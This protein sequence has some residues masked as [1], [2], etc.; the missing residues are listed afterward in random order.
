MSKALNFAVGSLFVISAALAV[1]AYSTNQQLV[2]EAASEAGY[3]FSQ[4]DDFKRN[5]VRNLLDDPDGQTIVGVAHELSLLRVDNTFAVCSDQDEIESSQY[6]ELA[7]I[8]DPLS[9]SAPK[10]SNEI[11]MI[12]SLDQGITDCQFRVIEAIA[13][14]STSS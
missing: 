3:T 6:L 10:V 12:L 4:V 13:Q 11:E 14:P 2:T 7:Q 1:A 8:I 9:D 5:A